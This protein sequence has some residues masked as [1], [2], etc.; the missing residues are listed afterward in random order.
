MSNS[1]QT[2]AAEL[3]QGF[4]L[5]ELGRGIGRLEM[6]AED[7]CIMGVCDDSRLAC[8]GYALMCLPRSGKHASEFAAVAEE[9]GATAIIA[10]GVTVDSE[11]PILHL[12][13]MQQAGQLLR[14]MFR[15]E[16]AGPHVYGIT[17]T[18]GKTSVAWMLREALSRYQE[19]PVWSSGTLGW[20]RSVD[21]IRDIGNTTPSMLTTRA[22]LAS[23]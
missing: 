22:M 19:R 17:G 8:P 10:V 23:A 1:A 13:D 14:R 16:G 7:V 20:M 18:D 15:T 6:D 21:D 11:L 9:K 5:R 4:S 2:R 12:K 3:A